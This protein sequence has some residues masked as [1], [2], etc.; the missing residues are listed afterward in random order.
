MVIS[1]I[2][3]RKLINIIHK[4]VYGVTLEILAVVSWCF[5]E[6]ISDTHAEIAFKVGKNLFKL[7]NYQN[8]SFSAQF[9]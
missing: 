1:P 3:S 6:R 7:L 4:T 8:V 9:Q 5:L 2:I